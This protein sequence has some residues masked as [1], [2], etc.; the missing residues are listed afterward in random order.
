[1]SLLGLGRRLGLIGLTALCGCL[2]LTHSHL[3]EGDRLAPWDTNRR[4]VVVAAGDLASDSYGDDEVGSLMTQLNFDAF[5]T[6]GDNAY[7]DG[8]LQNY[9]DY[10]SPVFGRYNSRTFPAPGN[11]DYFTPQARGYKA[12]FDSLAPNYPRNSEYY[13]FDIGGWRWFSLNS[14]IPS[15][16]TSAQFIWL[17]AQLE[18]SDLPSCV[19]A[20]W[21]RPLFTVGQE[22][23]DTQMVPTWN[24]LAHNVP[25][26][27]HIVLTGHDHNYQRWKVIDGITHFVVGTGG[28]FRFPITR[29]DSMIAVANADHYGVLQLGLWEGGA[30]FR[31]VTIDGVILDS[32]SISCY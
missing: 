29:S 7:P 15:D 20:Y 30:D 26:H 11:H 25:H 2:D 18:V 27:A 23:P 24:L 8:S 10:W 4:A 21:H 6:L 32:G 16:S 17:K 28:S 3:P 12:Y 9:G 5:L 31:F 22:D 13:A 19:G 14:E 1:M